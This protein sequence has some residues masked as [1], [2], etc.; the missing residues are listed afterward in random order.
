MHLVLWTNRQNRRENRVTPTETSHEELDLS[1]REPRLKLPRSDC[2]GFNGD[3]PIEWAIKCRYFFELYQVPDMWLATLHFQG[4]AEEW[5]GGAK[6]I[7][8]LC[9]PDRK[10]FQ[11]L[12]WHCYS[13]IIS[14]PL[15]V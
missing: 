3:N 1:R 4:R 2:P 12:I 5:Y 10:L 13:Q 6:Q 14:K 8:Y 15:Y 11:F 9:S 7:R